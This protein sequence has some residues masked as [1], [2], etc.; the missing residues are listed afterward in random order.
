MLLKSHSFVVIEHEHL[1]DCCSPS[2]VLF[3][4]WCLLTTCKLFPLDMAA[5]SECILRLQKGLR[6]SFKSER[7][8]PVCSQ[9]M[10]CCF[11]LLISCVRSDTAPL[12]MEI[13]PNP[14]RSR[15]RLVAFWTEPVAE[16]EHGGAGNSEAEG[17]PMAQNTSSFLLQHVVNSVAMIVLSKRSIYMASVL[18]SLAF[19]I[20]FQDSQR[21]AG[22][23][24]CKLSCPKGNSYLYKPITIGKD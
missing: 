7:T 9:E 18:P 10:G 13:A 20:S 4:W 17:F 11:L 19:S 3:W 1:N 12:H 22:V 8:Q 6:W 14:A 16:W 24:F 23:K 15:D 2:A 21:T 5:E